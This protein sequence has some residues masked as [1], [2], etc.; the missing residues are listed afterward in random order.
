M[1]G[2]EFYTIDDQLWVLDEF[3]NHTMVEEGNRELVSRLFGMIA[4]YWKEAFGALSKEFKSSSAN[5]AYF[6]WLVVR[7]FFKCNFGKLDTTHSDVLNGRFSF[8]KI[9]CPLRGE[10]KLEGIV[11]NPKF[12]SA[13]SQSQLRVMEQVYYGKSIEEISEMLFISQNTVKNHIKAS[14]WKLGIHEK[15]E[16]IRYANEKNLFSSHIV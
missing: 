4:D 3:G 12:N 9:D 1:E 5:V 15:A 8:E 10:C 16:F 14:Y 13:L 7:R 2:L 11:C 6:Q